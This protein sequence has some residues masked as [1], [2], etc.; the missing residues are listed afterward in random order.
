[1]RTEKHDPAFI[2]SKPLEL[3]MSEL[4]KNPGSDSVRSV[5]KYRVEKKFY[6]LNI[7]DRKSGTKVFSNITENDP[8]Y[9]YDRPDYGEASPQK[10][11]NAHAVSPDEK[12]VLLAFV[13]SIPNCDYTSTTFTY[14]NVFEIE[15]GKSYQRDFESS[16]RFSARSVINADFTS[17]GKYII[18]SFYDD[19][20]GNNLIA[21]A[22][23]FETGKIVMKTEEPEVPKSQVFSKPT[24]KESPKTDE[25]KY[26]KTAGSK[27]PLHDAETKK[28]VLLDEIRKL[29]GIHDLDILDWESAEK[30]LKLVGEG[31]LKKAHFDALKEI[32]PH[33]MEVAKKMKQ[34][35][36]K[37]IIGGA[38]TGL[39][40][41]A[42]R[43]LLKPDDE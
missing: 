3:A 32:A 8:C 43:I 22:W 5:R 10:Y 14:F 6:T 31:H 37:W 11:F 41:L 13:G 40:L 7:Y 25:T 30:I 29:S 12:Y 2:Q 17:D 33:I 28:A 9:C 23:D 15:T 38:A 20:D 16:K 19:R 42:G 4:L 18:A 35:K 24:R 21:L 34:N 39:G 1:M 26:S 27:K 36:W